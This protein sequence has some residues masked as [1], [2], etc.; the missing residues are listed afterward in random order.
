MWGWNS[1]GQ[2][3]VENESSFITNPTELI[4]KNEFTNEQVKFR[5]VS[6]G[7]R[8]SILIDIENNLYAFGWNKYGQIFK[9]NDVAY[10]LNQ[11]TN[12]EEPL[13]CFL[14]N[15]ITIDV[16]C[17]NWFNLILINKDEN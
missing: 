1:E 8:H 11:D 9:E 3:G 4:I 5:N 17:S 6:L 10:S 13:K 12:I 2:I 15:K 14:S 7:A 16:K